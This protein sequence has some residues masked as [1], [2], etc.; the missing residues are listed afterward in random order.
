MATF[1]DLAEKQHGKSLAI[2]D[3]ALY[4]RFAKVFK[5]ARL[6]EQGAEDIFCHQCDALLTS[7]DITAGYCTQC[8]KEI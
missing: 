5:K 4:D 6:A 1:R 2:R 3:M 8:G 7:T